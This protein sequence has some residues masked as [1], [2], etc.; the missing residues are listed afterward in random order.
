MRTERAALALAALALAACGG[1]GGSGAPVP[2]APAPP[3]FLTVAEVERAISQAAAEAGARGLRA[4]IVVVDRVGNVLGSHAMEGAPAGATIASGVAVGG[5]LEGTVVPAPFA[6]LSKAITG[7]YLSSNGNAFSTRTA[8]QIVQEH[9]NPQEPGQPSG[10]LYG[11]QFSQ[12]PCSDIALDASAGMA[13]PKRAPL[14][15]SADPGGLPLY[16]DG[17]LVGGIGVEG[18]GRYGFDRDL[19]DVDH[20]PE[21]LAAVA[22]AFGLAAPRDIRG[23]RIT[24]DGRTLRFLDSEALAT[25]PAV[26]PRIAIGGARAGVVFGTPESGVSVSFELRRAVQTLVGAGGPRYPVRTSDSLQLG[27]P[28]VERLLLEALAVAG[29]ARAQI[30]RPLG[31]TAQVNIAVVGNHGEVIGFART[32]DAPVFGI[33]VAV[34]KARTALFFS[35]DGNFGAPPNAYDALAGNP[36]VRYLD[37]ARAFLGDSTEFTGDTAWTPRAIGNLHR[38]F[39]P[40]G[41][42]GAP[43]GPLS[44]PIAQWS[45][46]NVGLQLDLVQPALMRVL[47]GEAVASCVPGTVLGNGLQIFPGGAPIYRAG[48]LMGAIGISGDGVDQD[49]M[50]AYLAVANNANVFGLGLG[51]ATPERRADRYAPQGARLR[52]VQCPQAPFVDSNQQNACA[53]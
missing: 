23:D 35:L 41:I 12:L 44:T 39:Y 43:T 6:A 9:F 40:D 51:H 38:P 53:P 21:E 8:G 2:A 22:G 52:Y 17:V 7:A 48:R 18:D 33:D 32:D 27:A 14:G 50:V 13:G 42:R 49:D 20:A 10:P 4:H 31:R 16:K 36:A 28:E 24:A 29:R 25:D 37:Q 15:L 46:F 45:P 5:G 30:R 26:A 1:G 11:V 19:L 47:A 3:S 34:Q